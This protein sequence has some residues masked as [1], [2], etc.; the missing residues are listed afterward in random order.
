MKGEIKPIYALASIVVVAVVLSAAWAAYVSMEPRKTIIQEPIETGPTPEPEKPAPD[1]VEVVQE[2]TETGGVP[3][4]LTRESTTENPN[5]ELE[6]NVPEGQRTCP[7]EVTYEICYYLQATDP[8]MGDNTNDW[9]PAIQACMEYIQ[10]QDDKMATI[11]GLCEDG[12]NPMTI[13]TAYL[14]G[15]I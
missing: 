8:T 12:F 7:V 4:E 10:G 9:S 11:T 2:I 14:E 1:P 15:G 3:V 5:N 13:A 6:Y